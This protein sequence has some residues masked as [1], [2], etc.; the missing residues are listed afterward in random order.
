MSS[1]PWSSSYAYDTR[2]HVSQQLRF[3]VARAGRDVLAFAPET[4][5]LRTSVQSSSISTEEWEEKKPFMTRKKGREGLA[6]RIIECE[7]ENTS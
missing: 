3:S 1:A 5:A 7:G 2:R 4:C 6:K